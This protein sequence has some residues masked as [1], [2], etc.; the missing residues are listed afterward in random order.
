MA[1]ATWITISVDDLDDCVVAA[2]MTA[3]RNAALGDSQDDP[4]AAVMP[5]II[6]RVRAEIQGNPINRVGAVA[7]TVPPSLKNQTCWL[8]VAALQ[9]RIPSLRLTDDQKDLIKDA[10]D[11]LKRVG[12]P[13]GIPIEQPDDVA[14]NDMQ[15]SGT[16]EM[17]ET[18]TLVTNDP[19][20][21]GIYL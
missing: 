2:Q 15:K 3:I 4:F 10:R 19:K 17:A 12:K 1:T 16:S 14:A 5:A 8:I 13:N 6:A 20:Q 18:P 7:N 21:Q 11:Y 9:P